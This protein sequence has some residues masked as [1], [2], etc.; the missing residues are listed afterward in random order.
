METLVVLHLII[1]LVIQQQTLILV[2]GNL[3]FSESTFSG[4]L[5]QMVY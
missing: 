3:R 1:L 5:T 2:Q 4:A